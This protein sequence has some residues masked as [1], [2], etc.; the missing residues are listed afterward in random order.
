VSKREKLVKLAVL[1]IIAAGFILGN[2]MVFSQSGISYASPMPYML[3]DVLDPDKAP[4]SIWGDVWYENM[5][6][7]AGVEVR[8][9][10]TDELFADYVYTD[11]FGEFHSEAMFDTG[12]LVKITIMEEVFVRQIPITDEESFYLGLFIV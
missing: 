12:Q 6:S 9:F 5:T 10:A 8:L 11:L 1:I 3:E 2:G 4:I 7:V